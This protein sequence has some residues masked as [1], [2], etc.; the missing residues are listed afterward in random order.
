MTSCS[1]SFPFLFFFLQPPEATLGW[2]GVRNS[3]TDPP[4][5]LQPD[6]L[7]HLRKM[8]GSEDCLYLNVY[9]PAVSRAPLLLLG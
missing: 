6:L 3:S 8:H 7:L 2:E 5:C 4:M 1:I 9:T